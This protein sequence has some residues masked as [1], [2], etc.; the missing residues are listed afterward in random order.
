[1]GSQLSGSR[2]AFVGGYAVPRESSR[3]KGSASRGEIFL[4][5]GKAKFIATRE[6]V[7]EF[8]F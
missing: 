5:M 4:K 3:V 1:M 8:V 2:A 7:I 6:I